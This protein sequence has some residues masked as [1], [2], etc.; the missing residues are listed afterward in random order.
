MGPRLVHGKAIQVGGGEKFTDDPRWMLPEGGG[1]LLELACMYGT[2]WRSLGR[3]SL[4]KM[5]DV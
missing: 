2:T 5:L 3:R 1:D 4:Q